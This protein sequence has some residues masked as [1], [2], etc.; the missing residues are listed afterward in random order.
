MSFALGM[1]GC[2]AHC[3]V[4]QIM[5]AFCEPNII[6]SE[7]P[8]LDAQSFQQHSGLLT[9]TKNLYS[10]KFAKRE[11][12]SENFLWCL[13]FFLWSFPL[14][15]SV[16]RLLH[17]D[18]LCLCISEPLVTHGPPLSIV[19]DLQSAS[20]PYVGFS[21]VIILCSRVM[22]VIIFFWCSYQ[23]AN[24]PSFTYTRGDRRQ[25]RLSR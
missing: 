21:V 11:S 7:N 5:L 20:V 23:S 3:L 22:N 15:I 6:K 25:N 14:S 4:K 1:T 12:E 24:K 8:F 13:N 2:I 17:A 18:N 9:L 10:E 19:I 16:N